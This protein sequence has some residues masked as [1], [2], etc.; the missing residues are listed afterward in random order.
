MT[1]QC[2]CPSWLNTPTRVSPA[3]Q[4]VL[5]VVGRAVVAIYRNRHATA[6]GGQGRSLQTSPDLGCSSLNS[7]DESQLAGRSCQWVC[8]SGGNLL[9][10]ALYQLAG[11]SRRR[12]RKTK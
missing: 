11:S 10:E 2:C 6:A 3:G 4:E 9:V 7:L 5:V 1:S 12:S 8:P